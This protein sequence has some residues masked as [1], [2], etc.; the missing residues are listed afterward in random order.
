MTPQTASAYARP[1][2]PFRSAR[3]TEYEVIARV[4]QR[5]AAAIPRREIDHPAFLEALFN[6][7]RLWST[8]ASD[9]AEPGNGLPQALRARLFYLYRFT[10]A[11]SEKLRAGSGAADVLIDINKAVL[12]GLR[13]EAAP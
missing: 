11:H 9:V 1:A 13:G 8:L 3:D 5:L 6:N 4:T 12:R 2:A 7:E 10:V